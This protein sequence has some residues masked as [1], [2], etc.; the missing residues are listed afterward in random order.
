[1]SNIAER[2]ERVRKL[3][4]EILMFP[5]KGVFEETEFVTF[6]DVLMSSINYWQELAYSNPQD[7]VEGHPLSDEDDADDEDKV[8]DT[9]EL[10]EAAGERA[11]IY[12][13]T[14]GRFLTV[15]T[16]I[17]LN[18]IPRAT[19]RELFKEALPALKHV[20]AAQEVEGQVYT[21]IKTDVMG[22]DFYERSRIIKVEIVP[23]VKELARELGVHLRLPKNELGG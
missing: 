20:V 16:K 3:A 12:I 2:D 22:I 6:S 4:S 11:N 15:L 1:M 10:Y 7:V 14:I 19:D 13:E 21:E 9:V 18:G 23:K 17:A 5:M 8:E